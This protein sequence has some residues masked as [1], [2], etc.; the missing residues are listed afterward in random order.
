MND[1]S[2]NK[3]TDISETLLVPL[4]AR[5]FETKSEKPIITDQ[6]AVEITNKLNKIFEKSNSTLHRRLATGKTRKRLNKKLNA[7]MALRTKKFDSYCTDFIKKNPN[8]II[9]EL[10]CGLST[11]F[12]RI[13]NK[14]LIWY[15]LD[16]PEVIEIRKQFFKET[17]RYNFIASSVLDFKWMDQ[18]KNKEGKILFIA[19]GLLPY[20][21]EEDVKN[22]VLKLKDMF[23]G[24]ELA[25]EVSNI[26][27]VKMFKRKIFRK[28]FQRDF[29]FGPETTFH[30]GIKDSREFEKWN[31]EIEFLDDWT[32][33]DE[34]EKKLGWINIFRF[35]KKLKKTQW[36]VHY[37]L[38]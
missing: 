32:Y 2:I 10:G 26:F 24:C 34:R 20:L 18:L 27:I 33:F 15:D 9:V 35:S 30:F 19:E 23:P 3:I 25:C 37:L 8:G 7:T 22:L 36:I 11:R 28:K 12:E 21:H 29:N 16:F 38:K 31:K 17:N 1:K 13:D 4:Y 5:A 14:K 6:K